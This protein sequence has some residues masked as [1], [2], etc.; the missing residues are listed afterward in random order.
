MAYSSWLRNWHRSG[1]Q[2]RR[3]TPAPERY[4]ADH[5]SRLETLEDRFLL[6]TLTVLNNL[7]SGPGSLRSHV[8]GFQRSRVPW[9]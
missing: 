2:Q 3:R 8:G 6:S 4:R 5:R 1:P 9:E 7:D